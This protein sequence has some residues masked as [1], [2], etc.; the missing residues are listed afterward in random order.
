[1]KSF[2]KSRAQ[3]QAVTE[4]T[5]YTTLT[6]TYHLRR[7]V[8]VQYVLLVQCSVPLLI[9]QQLFAAQNMSSTLSEYHYNLLMLLKVACW[10]RDPRFVYQLATGSTTED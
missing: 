5:T 9:L 10:G 2:C 4:L 3:L 6:C 8:Q 1:L 7:L